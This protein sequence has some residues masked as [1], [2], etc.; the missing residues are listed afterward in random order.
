MAVAVAGALDRLPGDILDRAPFAPGER[1][2]ITTDLELATAAICET[3]GPAR[4]EVRGRSPDFE[5][6]LRRFRALGV[7]LSLMSVGTDIAVTGSPPP[8]QY[9]VVIP[10]AGHLTAGAR[11]QVCELSRSTG[12]VISPKQPVFFSD[13]TGDCRILCVRIAQAK[14]DSALSL[15]LRRPVRETAEFAFRLDVSAMHSAPLMRALELAAL[16]VL[17]ADSSAV[18]SALASNISQLVIN[19]LLLSQDHTFADELR[20]PVI[21]PDFPQP[22]RI[23]QQFIIDHAADPIGIG[24]IASAAN[25]SVRALE[26]GFARYLRVAPMA[27]L[28]DVRLAL[29]HEQLCRSTPEETTVRSVAQRWGFRHAGRFSNTYRQRFGVSP[30]EALRA[31]HYC[32]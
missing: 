28:R 13:W 27:Y 18:H 22:L 24:D 5:L 3:Y 6:D 17:E 29:A 23:A 20:K 26:G 21:D 10:A 8:D 25:V 2:T 31:R 15:M 12:I 7:E 19:S 14:V 30:S 4:L 11:G 32:A 9:V 16:E 1:R